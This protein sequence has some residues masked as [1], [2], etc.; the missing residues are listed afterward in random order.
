[1][2]GSTTWSFTTD[3]LQ[4]AVA[5]HVPAS[6]ATG[7]AVS[8]N[9]QRHV[10]RGR[11]MGHVHAH[12]QRGDF[13]RGG[14]VLQQHDQ[15]RDVHADRGAGVRDDLHGHRQRRQG[16]GRRS[17]ERIDLL[18]VHHCRQYCLLRLSHWKRQ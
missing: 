11:A 14:P 8:G 13:R 3:P 4:P 1:M 10:Q 15:H 6:S 7:V 17:D 2:S 16:R 5:S 9:P 12:Q 18:V